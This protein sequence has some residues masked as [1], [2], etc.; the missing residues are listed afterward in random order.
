MAAA[1]ILVMGV[2]FAVYLRSTK[3]QGVDFAAIN[4]VYAQ[5]QVQYTSQIETQRSEL[6]SIEKSDP[7]LYKEFSDEIAQMDSTYKDMNSDPAT[8]PNQERVLHAI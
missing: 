2:S 3:K 1:V 5:Q 8:S 6:K 4:P 7:Q